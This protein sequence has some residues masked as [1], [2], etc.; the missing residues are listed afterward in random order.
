MKTCPVSLSPSPCLP[1]TTSTNPE[2][3]TNIQNKQHSNT[4]GDNILFLS[5]I[6]GVVLD[7]EL[8]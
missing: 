2:K 5:P 1:I 8:Q 6:N 3:I 7:K 4:A